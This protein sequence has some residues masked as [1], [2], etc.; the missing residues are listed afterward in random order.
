ME[1]NKTINWKDMKDLWHNT[2]YNEKRI[3]PTIKDKKLSKNDRRILR[4]IVR[5][6]SKTH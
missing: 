4:Q 1:E 5:D 6:K 3:A 2:F